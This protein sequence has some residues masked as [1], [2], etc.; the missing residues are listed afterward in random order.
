MTFYR[1]RFFTSIADG[2][3]ESLNVIVYLLPTGVRSFLANKLPRMAS[4][5]RGEYSKKLLRKLWMSRQAQLERL[6]RSCPDTT[7]LRASGVLVFAPTPPSVNGIGTYALRLATE[8]DKRSG[9]RI[10]VSGATPDHRCS[11]LTTAKPTS[12]PATQRHRRLYMLGNGLDHWE[13]WHYLHEQP[14]PVLLHDV[15]IQDLP[16]L[17]SES[18]HWARMSYQEKT[19][20]HLARLPRLTPVVLVHNRA[21][22]ESAIEQFQKAGVDAPEIMVLTT[23]HPVHQTRNSVR[24][25]PKGRVTIGTAGIQDSRKDVFRTYHSI[26]RACAQLDADGIVVGQ[27]SQRLKSA[28]LQ[29]WRWYG[30][31]SR[32]FRFEADVT[33]DQYQSLCDEIDI[34]VLLRSRDDKSASGPVLDMLSR[35]VPTVASDTSS[36]QGVPESA[37][38]RVPI[39]ASPK[40]ISSNLIKLARDS[41]VYGSIS[42]AAI[43][44]CSKKSFGALAEELLG[45]VN[46]LPEH[47]PAR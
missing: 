25:F 17:D 35:G 23:G 15:C 21:A 32:K 27:A 5:L 41:E 4:F 24:F 26:S 12:F 9:A 2:L 14:G 29:I 1:K 3:R 11:E 18:P 40:R 6:L 33:D 47:P 46:E 28:A 20:T 39:G 10:V 13:T 43:L 37:L 30:N 7:P 44:H 38:L 34:A 45:I 31:P 19:E 22:K 42:N 8:L 36:I 16:L